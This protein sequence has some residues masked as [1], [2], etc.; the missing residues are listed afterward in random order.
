AVIEAFHKLGLPLV[1]V[2]EGPERDMLERIAPSPV[3]FTGFVTDQALALLYQSARAVIFPSEED[4]GMVAAEALS[5]GTPVIAYEYG[6]VQAIVQPRVTGEL[7]PA[8]TPEVIAEGVRRFLAREGQYDGEVM[9]QSV[10][11]LTKK[12]FQEEMRECI[13]Q[14][15]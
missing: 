7:F 3:R 13:E 9:K 14:Y 4:F 1:I 15:I 6:G 5:F 12:R 2:G 10:A 11:H 8:Q